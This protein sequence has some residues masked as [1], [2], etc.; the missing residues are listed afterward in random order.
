LKTAAYE[1]EII[2]G[3]GVAARLFRDGVNTDCCAIDFES[4]TLS[5]RARVDSLTVVFYGSKVFYCKTAQRSET[6]RESV[7]SGVALKN[8]LRN[9]AKTRAK[10]LS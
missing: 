3:E 2:H 8:R 9:I 6:P 5:A 4:S 10:T 1:T 7:C